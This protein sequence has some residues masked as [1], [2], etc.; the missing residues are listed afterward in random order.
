MQKLMVSN[1]R[2]SGEFHN[3][4]VAYRGLTKIEL[5]RMKVVSHKFGVIPQPMLNHSDDVRRPERRRSEKVV[6]KG[7]MNRTCRDWHAISA[8]RHDHIAI[9]LLVSNVDGMEHVEVVGS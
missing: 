2:K 8:V 3:V 9:A 1:N 6:G 4:S 5:T 7:G